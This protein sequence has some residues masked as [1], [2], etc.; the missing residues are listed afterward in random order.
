MN[1]PM[2]QVPA[3]YTRLA[4]GRGMVSSQA[5][6]ILNTCLKIH[7]FASTKTFIVLVAKVSWFGAGLLKSWPRHWLTE[8]AKAITF[9]DHPY[10]ATPKSVWRN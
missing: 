1:L 2:L 3:L 8:L 6:M 4:V 7:V 10:H 5:A 9:L